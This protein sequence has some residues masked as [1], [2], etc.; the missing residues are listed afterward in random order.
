[1]LLDLG[2]VGERMARDVRTGEQLVEVHAVGGFGGGRSVTAAHV[3]VSS[4]YIRFL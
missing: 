1:M 2:S 3:V 4:S